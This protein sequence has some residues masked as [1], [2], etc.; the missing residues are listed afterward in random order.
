MGFLSKV[1]GRAKSTSKSGPAERTEQQLALQDQAVQV[2][3]IQLGNIQQQTE[4]QS[5]LFAQL[6]RGLEQ[7]GG[8]DRSLFGGAP[9]ATTQSGD[10]RS[11]FVDKQQL[12]L[13]D[14]KKQRGGGGGGASIASRP[15]SGLRF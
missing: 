2:G 10:R 15:P 4:F 12:A 9:P 11:A 7:R 8:V 3:D 14:F 1:F 6:M 5:N 13:E